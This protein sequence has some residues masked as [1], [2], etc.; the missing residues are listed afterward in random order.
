MHN[1]TNDMRRCRHL[2]RGQDFKGLCPGVTP[3]ECPL[4]PAAAEKEREAS[5]GAAEGRP[6]RRGLSPASKSARPEAPVRGGSVWWRS[7]DGGM[8]ESP[9]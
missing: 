2:S 5:A 8:A 9:W 3:D 6:F 7:L 1:L 4:K